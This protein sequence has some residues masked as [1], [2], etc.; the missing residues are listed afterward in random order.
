MFS[1]VTNHSCL[2]SPKQLRVNRQT[3]G[4]VLIKLYLQIGGFAALP[5]TPQRTVKTDCGE[6]TLEKT[7]WRSKC[8][9]KWSDRQTLT[10]KETQKWDRYLVMLLQM[11]VV[12]LRIFQPFLTD[13]LVWLKLAF[14]IHLIINIPVHQSTTSELPSLWSCNFLPL[15]N[16]NP[17]G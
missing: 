12:N 17:C 1:A 5:A 11:N 15:F 16:I 2:C 10:R 3:N 8:L 4:H 13:F 14:A 7:A 6:R 9:P